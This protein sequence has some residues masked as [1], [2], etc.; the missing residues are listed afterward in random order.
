MVQ[1][2]EPSLTPTRTCHHVTI[3]TTLILRIAILFY[4]YGLTLG[5]E[6]NLFWKQSKRSWPF[7]LFTFNRYIA[8]L[9]HILILAYTFLQL[10]GSVCILLLTE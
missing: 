6:I 1:S 8:L 7:V 9:N 4:D 2:C 10:P 5:E 3:L